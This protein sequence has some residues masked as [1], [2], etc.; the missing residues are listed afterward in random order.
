MR[1]SALISAALFLGC[2]SNGSTSTTTITCP[3]KSTFQATFDQTARF[4]RCKGVNC[5]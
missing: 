2:S 5:P 4:N 3:D 1:R